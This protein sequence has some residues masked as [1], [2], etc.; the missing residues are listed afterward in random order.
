MKGHEWTDSQLALLYEV[1][2]VETNAHTAALLGFS[3]S[4]VKRKACSL[5]IGKIAKTIWLERAEYILG[6][7]HERSFAEM[8]RDLG[9]SKM[10]VSR[11][12]ARLG[13]RRTVKERRQVAS[14]VRREMIRRER[15]RVVFGLEPVTQ[16]KVVSNRARVRLR[17]VLK[18][19]GYLVG[20]D[21]RTIYFGR[22][23][24]R[25]ERL[26]TRGRKLGL[27]FLPLPDSQLFKQNQTNTPCNTDK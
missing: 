21:C 1:Y 5:G 20:D 16:I 17:A 19:K 8:A 26:E 12:A 22:N 4:V 9:I 25:H 24:H 3:E 18:S 23:L 11:I 2:P 14:R 27:A 15:R 7:F 13:L 10:S 6:H